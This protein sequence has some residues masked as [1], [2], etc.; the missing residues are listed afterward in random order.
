MYEEP[1][2]F[3]K[4]LGYKY[5]ASERIG[6]ESAHKETPIADGIGYYSNGWRYV[7]RFEEIPPVVNKGRIGIDE[8]IERAVTAEIAYRKQ[9]AHDKYI[10]RKN[11]MTTECAVCGSKFVRRRNTS[12]YCSERCH[13]AR[14][15]IANCRK[16]G[17]SD[18]YMLKSKS[19]YKKEIMMLLEREKQKGRK[20]I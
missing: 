16:D 7:W 5:I 13:G 1:Y 9:K 14:T 6:V 17:K 12:R 19:K 11:K 4:N 2:I 10:E 18:D 8:A 3:L 20:L 15:Y